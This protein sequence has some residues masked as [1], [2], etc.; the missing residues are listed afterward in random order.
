MPREARAATEG[1]DRMSDATRRSFLAATGLGTAAAVAVAV[2]PGVSSAATTNE[3][4]TVPAGSAGDLA[5]YVK[6]VHKGDVVLMV[7]GREVVVTD[8]NLVAR[9]AQAY[10]K[11]GR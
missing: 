1:R 9:L 4:A 8:K 7:D 6:D 3:E 2:V 10:A 5:A 11:A